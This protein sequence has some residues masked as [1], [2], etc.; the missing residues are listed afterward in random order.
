MDYIISDTHFN[1]EK[2][3]Y[4]D[5]SRADSLRA[6]GIEPTIENMDEYLEKKWNETIGNEDMVYFLGDLGMFSKKQAFVAQL[7][8]L[9]GQKIFFKGNHDH[10]DQLKAALKEPATQLIEVVETAKILKINGHTVWLSHYAIDVPYPLIS[11]HGHIHEAEYRSAGMVNVSLDSALMQT[12]PF[13][14][15]MPLDEL[16]AVLVK[17]KAIIAQ[18]YHIESEN[19]RYDR[20]IERAFDETITINKPT[21]TQ[22]HELALLV[23]YLNQNNLTYADVLTKFNIPNVNKVL[24]SAEKEQV[25]QTG[26][27]FEK[28]I[29]MKGNSGG[30]I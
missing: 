30:E 10:S 29:G 13:G 12:R 17:N 1:H 21:A 4:F 18:E 8:R 19:K 6:L 16:D 26:F 14:Q 9:N 20:L 2:I 28:L 22:R 24:S 7:V 23:A 3:L 27:E 15:P 5:K 11:V 25:T